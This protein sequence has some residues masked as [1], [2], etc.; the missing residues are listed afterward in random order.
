MSN[1]SHLVKPVD[2]N[3]GVFNW[4]S[5]VAFVIFKLRIVTHIHVLMLYLTMRYNEKL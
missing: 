1:G 4:K 5:I 2:L 3:I